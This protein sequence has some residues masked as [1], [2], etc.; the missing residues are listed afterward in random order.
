[1][2][3]LLWD[4]AISVSRSVAKASSEAL[5]RHAGTPQAQQFCDARQSL[6]IA[7]I[8]EALV[9][10]AEVD[11]PLADALAARRRLSAQLKRE[12]V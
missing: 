11:E 4:T 12:V 8:E 7:S 6:D 5:L 1:M 2:S 10:L 3:H 9:I